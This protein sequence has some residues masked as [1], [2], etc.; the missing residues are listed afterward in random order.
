MYEQ[1]EMVP[2]KDNH[3][4]AVETT[5]MLLYDVPKPLHPLGENI[6]S[7]LMDDR[8]RNAMMYPPPPNWLQNAVLNGLH[9][10]KYIIRYLFL[11]RPYS[12]RMRAISEKPNKNGKYNVL[13]YEVEPWY[14]P[15]TF[16]YRWI[17]P[18]T[19]R[20]WLQ[21]RP[22]PG[23]KYRPEGYD[24]PNIGPMHLEGKGSVEMSATREK[25]A[26]AKRGGCP[27]A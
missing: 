7:S 20:K 25:F 19:W 23:P 15:D 9:L 4:T 1:K 17:S 8:L 3:Q 14:F 21:G 11:P 2:S 12:M 5:A 6:V 18:K 24:I 22:I 16:Y 26:T 13:Y 27:F 10:R